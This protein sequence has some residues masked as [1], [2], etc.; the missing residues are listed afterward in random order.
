MDNNNNN[1]TFR[2]YENGRMVHQDEFPRL[3][4][5]YGDYGYEYNEVVIPD[6]VLYDME[7]YDWP[8]PKASYPETP[9]IDTSYVSIHDRLRAAHPDMPY[10]TNHT[11]DC[12]WEWMWIESK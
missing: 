2:F 5:D 10:M 11:L 1:T 12:I 7:N 3:D 6:S 8:D 4:N 9:F